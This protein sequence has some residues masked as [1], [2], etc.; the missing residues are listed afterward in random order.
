MRKLFFIFNYDTLK[1]TYERKQRQENDEKSQSFS[2]NSK[3]KHYF[4]AGGCCF[5]GEGFAG[6]FGVAGLAAA[7]GAD[8]GGGGARA[9][10]PDFFKSM[11]SRNGLFSGMANCKK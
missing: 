8:E 6:D 9:G 7:A 10:T 3:F 4:L 2:V 1:N 5:D 11:S